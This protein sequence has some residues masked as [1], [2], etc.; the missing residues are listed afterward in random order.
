MLVSYFSALELLDNRTAEVLQNIAPEK[1]CEIQEIRLRTEKPLSVSLNGK[2][3]FVRPDSS[4]SNNFCEGI[5]VKR[6]QLIESVKKI[7]GNSIYSHLDEIENGFI[8]MPHGCR[9]G[10]SGVF[11]QDKFCEA[12]CVNIR[13]AHE[14]RGVAKNIIEAYSGGSL[15]ICGPPCSGKTTFLRDLI[16]GL[17]NGESGR[18]YKISVIDTRYEIAAYSDGISQN[19]IGVNTDIFWGRNKADGAEAA[20]RSMS[21]EIIAFDEIGT[22]RE[23]EAVKSSMNCGVYIITTAHIANINELY[24]RNV[25]KKL[26]ED[27]SIDKIIYLKYVGCKPII[28]NVKDNELCF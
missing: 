17:S 4:L 6:Q 20:I 25:T 7:T 26:I 24:K 19:D 3:Y 13:I 16:R 21:P 2:I 12:T 28:L 9:A 23:L 18:F 8:S 5:I 22:V 14:C 10:I 27:C 15:L 11:R 1:V